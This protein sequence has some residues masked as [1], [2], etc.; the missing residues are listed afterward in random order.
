LAGAAVAV[1][2]EQ[3]SGTFH[4]C[5]D[6][7][8]DK[9]APGVLSL[10]LR[11]S[12]SAR[13]FASAGNITMGG[14]AIKANGLNVMAMEPGVW[15]HIE[16]A[17]RFGLHPDKMLTISATAVDGRSRVMEA[18]YENV[19]F[20]RPTWLGLA[21]VGRVGSV[22]HVDNVVLAVDKGRR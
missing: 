14:G 11:D 10:M 3:K 2:A 15:Y 18:P 12:K 17:C 5:L 7:M 6:V 4:A 9:D 16:I 8:L 22:I 13:P 19:L 1:P 20:D 21:G